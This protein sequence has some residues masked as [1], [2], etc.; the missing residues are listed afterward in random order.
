VS[1]SN[2]DALCTGAGAA[3]R[4]RDRMRDGPKS[5]EGKVYQ[6]APSMV[7]PFS[8]LESPSPDRSG[9]LPLDAEPGA[10]DDE[11]REVEHKERETDAERASRLRD[12][13][14]SKG[15]AGESGQMQFQIQTQAATPR[16]HNMAIELSSLSSDHLLPLPR[17]GES[18]SPSSQ[19]RLLRSQQIAG[20]VGVML[21]INPASKHGNSGGGPVQRAQSP[22]SGRS[23]HSAHTPTHGKT[24]PTHSSRGAQSPMQGA[25]HALA[26]ALSINVKSKDSESARMSP[27]RELQMTLPGSPTEH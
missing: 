23:A 4:S 11:Q 13:R 17:P 3:D 21:E 19:S 10:L 16:R 25:G 2:S 14:E 8:R 5:R 18:Q 27:T 26:P 15:A 22:V 7:S 9:L 12:D 6:G 1:S 20:G 24:T